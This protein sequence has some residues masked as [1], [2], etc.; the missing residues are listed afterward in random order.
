[1][2]KYQNYLWHKKKKA[3]VSDFKGLEFNS[4]VNF[5]WYFFTFLNI[6][7]NFLLKY[8]HIQV[9]TQIINAQLDNYHKYIFLRVPRVILM[10]SQELK[11]L[12]LSLY[13][14][15]SANIYLA[16]QVTDQMQSPPPRSYVFS[17]NP[18]Y[19]SCTYYWE[20]VVFF[21]VFKGKNS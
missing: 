3:R 13:F 12:P 1:M 11:L 14:L 17:G 9:S 7:F 2:A 6:I 4:A 5:F 19:R 16:L 18:V 21:K 8:R 10:N 20:Y 15:C